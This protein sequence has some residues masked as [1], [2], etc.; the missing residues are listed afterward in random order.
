MKRIAEIT[1]ALNTMQEDE[2]DRKQTLADASSETVVDQSESPVIEK[3]SAAG[4]LKS[5]EGDESTEMA[6]YQIPFY[7]QQLSYKDVTRNMRTA[8]Q[9]IAPIPSTPQHSR[10]SNPL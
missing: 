10:Q 7:G 2:C 1:P 4:S 9:H 3:E 8:E 5:P 6:H